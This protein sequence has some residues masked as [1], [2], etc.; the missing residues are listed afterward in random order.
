MKTCCCI[1]LAYL[2]E[3]LVI[4]AW[5]GGNSIDQVGALRQIKAQ[6][7][8]RRLRE[9]LGVHKGVE[10]LLVLKT[11]IACLGREIKRWVGDGTAGN[12]CFFSHPGRAFQWNV[13]TVNKKM[14]RKY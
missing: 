9:V 5:G 7:H 11:E 6:F 12:S 2:H 10:K 14:I 1:D 4:K 3:N 13:R 8:P